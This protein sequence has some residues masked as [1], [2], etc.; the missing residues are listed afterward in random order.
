[1]ISNT[2]RK[3]IVPSHW[4]INELKSR[5]QKNSKYTLRAFARDLNLSPAYL[6]QII[7]GK[8][9]ISL[10]R[11]Q[12]ISQKLNL[13]DN[14]YQK[15]LETVAKENGIKSNARSI[16]A[17]L[18]NQNI[19]MTDIFE[20]SQKI[21]MDQIECLKTWYHI[22]ILELTTCENF[23]SDIKWIS[24]KL[25]IPQVEVCDAI[26][27][28]LRL[29]LLKEDQNKWIKTNKKLSISTT[30]SLSA[31]REF[32]KQTS[33]KAIECMNRNTTEKDFKK[34]SIIGA[35]MAMNPNKIEEAKRIS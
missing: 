12:D 20:D 1:M 7:Q 34:R 28:L 19:S 11:V 30:K 15:F 35:T 18:L 13:S 14:E 31:V 5:Q 3:K 2:E 24:K 25:K 8:K 33:N 6:S 21:E 10:H 9:M 23:K 29:G 4:I 32:H 17:P 22:A 27:R 16:L 26:E